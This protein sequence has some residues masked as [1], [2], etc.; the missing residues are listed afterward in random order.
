MLREAIAIASANG[1]RDELKLANAAIAALRQREQILR[2]SR[3]LAADGK[4]GL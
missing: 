2:S 3:R 1:E 4:S